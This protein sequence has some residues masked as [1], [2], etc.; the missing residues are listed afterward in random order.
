MG[1]KKYLNPKKDDFGP[2]KIDRPPPPTMGQDPARLA[3]PYL[4]VI[5]EEGKPPSTFLKNPG[6]CWY[7]PP[8][9]GWNPLELFNGGEVECDCHKMGTC[10]QGEPLPPSTF[11]FEQDPAYNYTG[12]PLAKSPELFK[13]HW[14]VKTHQRPGVAAKFPPKRSIVRRGKDQGQ[15]KGPVLPELSY[16][17]A[18]LRAF[19]EL[20]KFVKENILETFGGVKPFTVDESLHLK[21]GDQVFDPRA[22]FATLL[23][24]PGKPAG[25]AIMPMP[26][27]N[28]NLLTH[29][30]ENA[31]DFTKNEALPESLKHRSP[32]NLSQSLAYYNFFARFT[33]YWRTY[34]PPGLFHNLDA[35][36]TF[37]F[38]TIENNSTT[39]H[40][41][42]FGD[43]C[44]DIWDT[45]LKQI[46]SETSYVASVDET[47]A[48]VHEMVDRSASEGKGKHSIYMDSVVF[49]G[50][51]NPAK[52][53]WTDRRLEAVFGSA[54]PSV[55]ITLAYL[56]LTLWTGHPQWNHTLEG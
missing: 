46:D 34:T 23:S 14:F 5:I 21:E 29:C 8:K 41:D 54:K 32:K 3:D 47:M 20:P 35:R 33:T 15:G 6:A 26:A 44:D 2:Q 37:T 10:S 22:V 48:A 12:P 16:Y 31:I 24:N 38:T 25:V 13:N 36:N 50:S 40:T 43:I 30:T 17:H 52:L 39:V 19:R 1:L 7:G 49:A 9:I 56:A 55:Q 18:V 42:D 11:E 51:W 45:A 4:D 28:L 53:D 27:K